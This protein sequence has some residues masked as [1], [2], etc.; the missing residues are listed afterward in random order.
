MR[1]VI[2]H[3]VM[4]VMLF[5]SLESAVDAST[6]IPQHG[7]GTAHETHHGP[8]PM[9]DHDDDCSHFCHCVSHLFSLTI[10]NRTIEDFQPASQVLPKATERYSSRLVAP[11]LRPPIS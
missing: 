5:C 11:P 6:I 3:I 9:P 10:V 1:S 2:L 4:G 8:G 7:S